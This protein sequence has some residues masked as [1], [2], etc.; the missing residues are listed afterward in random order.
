MRSR[1][2]NYLQI[3]V[4]VTGVIYISIGV[5]FYLAPFAVVRIF[6]ELPAEN[7]IDMVKKSEFV[8]IL[9]HMA[10]VLAALLFVSGFAMMLP[11][12]DPL[13]Y[14]GLIYFNGVIFPFFAVLLGLFQAGF[15]IREAVEQTLFTVLLYF[16]ALFLFIFIL[17]LTGLV[18]TMKQT[19]EG[20]E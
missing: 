12:F 18:I 1:Y 19:K 17:N 20:I 3:I 4:L 14:R 15:I 8:V 2:T 10:R 7:W 13:R 6:M 11:L 16:Y 9:Y 5:L